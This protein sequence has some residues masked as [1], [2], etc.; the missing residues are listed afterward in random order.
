MTSD[1][2]RRRYLTRLKN[3]EQARDLLQQ[4]G[5]DNDVDV[6]EDEVDDIMREMG[7]AISE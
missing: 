4:N 3:E 2:G 5:D 1:E 7:I 6:V